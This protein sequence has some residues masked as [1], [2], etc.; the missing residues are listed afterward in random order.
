MNE[1]TFFFSLIYTMSGYLS[2][3]GDSSYLNIN[4]NSTLEL[5]SLHI[6]ST[7]IDAFQVHRDTSGGVVF[8]VDTSTPSVTINADLTVNGNITQTEAKDISTNDV[9][10]H[11]AKNNALISD[12]YDQGVYGEYK[13]STTKYWSLYRDASDSGIFKL[14]NEIGTL[15]TTTVASGT[16]AKLRVGSLLVNTTEITPTIANYLSSVN[17]NLSTTSN[18]TFGNIAGVLSTGSQPG[19]TSLGALT[20]LTTA[21]TAELELASTFT[22][23]Q[24]LGGN[25]KITQYGNTGAYGSGI[26]CSHARGTSGSMTPLQSGDVV[27]GWWSR[28]CNIN[29]SFS[30]NTS[31]IRTC[32]PSTWT[33]TS[34]ETCIDFA[35]TPLNATSRTIRMLLNGYGGLTVGNA[36][37]LA[38]TTYKLYSNGSSYINGN[39]SVNGVAKLTDG[40]A[41]AP[42]ISFMNDAQTGFYRH[43]ATSIGISLGGTG[44]VV[45]QSNLATALNLFHEPYGPTYSS[46]SGLNSP[47][48]DVCN[49]MA[50]GGS[51]MFCGQV[52]FLTSGTAS[53]ASFQ[54]TLPVAA[55][56]DDTVFIAGTISGTCGT[57]LVIGSP[58]NVGS[59]SVIGVDLKCNNTWASSASILLNFSLMY[60]C[61]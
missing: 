36:S 51:I 38:S 19:I 57:Y 14:Q 31:A 34:C 59:Q 2:L 21:T 8:T 43:N 45:N 24:G 40:N 44:Y 27:S 15:P 13:N 10:I 61:Y 33:S 18:V 11:L 55:S 32:C 30:G 39:L 58:S 47:S 3:S 7:A 4:R 6:D 53:A 25:V 22:T 37:D 28:G 54:M 42:S 23:G 46:L 50:V 5:H 60:R 1:K 41:A 16:D 12:T 52:Q 56:G 49:V 35:T 29:G 9:L 20:G 26:S 17:Q 48:S